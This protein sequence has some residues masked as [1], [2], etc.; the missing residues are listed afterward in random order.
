MLPYDDAA[1]MSWY[2]TGA[3]QYVQYL[4]EITL[5]TVEL[6]EQLEI[7]VKGKAGMPF[8]LRPYKIGAW[9]WDTSKTVTFTGAADDFVSLVLDDIT[10][11]QSGNIVRFSIMSTT[12]LG[13]AGGYLALD[14]NYMD[15]RNLYRLIRKSPFIRTGP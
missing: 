3:W 1:S 5:P 10:N 4:V 15:I 8:T 14:I 9:I 11:Y 12:A 7:R 13:S 6:L 2:A